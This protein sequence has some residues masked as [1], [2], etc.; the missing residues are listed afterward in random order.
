MT[1]KSLLPLCMSAL[2]L[3]AFACSTPTPE[4]P[5][6]DV[7]FA[8]AHIV[9]GLGN[10]G[11]TGHLAIQGDKIALLSTVPIPEEATLNYL[12]LKG[13]VLSPGFIDNHAHIQTSI[14]EYPLAENFTRQ[15]ITTI[16]ASLHSGDQPFP[17][18]T[19][20]KSLQ[21]VPNVGFFAG[22][23]WARKQV[24]GLENRAPEPQ[25]LEAMKKL[26]EQS[27]QQGALGLS[28]GLLYVPAN[29]AQTEEVIELAKVASRY[30]GIY[31]THMRDEATGLLASVDE[32]IRIAREANIPAQINHHKAVGVTQWGWSETSLARIDAARAEGID[33]THDLYPYTASSTGS[34]VLFPQWALAG[35]KE[36]FAERVKDK[37]QLQRMKAE[38]RQIF[39]M[40]RTGGDLN[41][42][43]FRVLP[44]NPEFNGKT[45]ADYAASLDLP[46]SLDVGIELAIDLQLKGGFSAIYHA[47]EEQDVIR[48][49]QHPLSMIETDG[50]PVAYGVGFP[51]PRSYGSFPRILARYVRELKV[52]S[53]EEAIKKMTSMAADQYNQPL[54]GRLQEGAFA[55]LVVFDPET[56]Q[57]QATYTDPH[58]Y[59]LG[60]DHVLVN[61]KFVLKSGALTGERPGKWIKGPARPQ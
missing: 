52:I 8:N 5:L 29:F 17:I 15:G 1:F 21:V 24:L 34:S 2:L 10:P 11:Y 57:D 28:T 48:I 36:A 54:R 38:M 14:H 60:I 7:V 59:P 16:M 39:E 32:T 58:S 43:Q 44:S 33:I 53:L 9:D 50:D 30:G 31:V 40:E 13:K 46:N 35:G 12:D 18:D 20:A 45:M 19:Y 22:H 23:S 55:D 61:G 51:H 41:R 26:V 27:M 3:S 42:L 25:E 49:L 37:D 47:M 56:I 4:K 6:Y